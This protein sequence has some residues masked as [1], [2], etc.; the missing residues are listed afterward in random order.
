MHFRLKSRDN[1][2][3]LTNESPKHRWA[4]GVS[5]GVDPHLFR[6]FMP[7]LS[8]NRPHPLEKGF[9]TPSSL[10][11]GFLTDDGFFLEFFFEK[12][13]LPKKISPAKF[14]SQKSPNQ[15]ILA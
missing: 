15:A 11:F 1:A 3:F 2:A 7:P 6:F 13:D 5:G 10:D 14:F 8:S 9:L 4:R 12:S